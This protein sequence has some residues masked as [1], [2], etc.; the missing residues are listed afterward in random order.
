MDRVKTGSLIDRAKSNGPESDPGV[1]RP[2][3][4][5]RIHRLEGAL[6]KNLRVLQECGMREHGSGGRRIRGRIER[7]RGG[8]SGREA[9]PA[10][11]GR[12]GR[13]RRTPAPS[14]SP[15]AWVASREGGGRA[16]EVCRFGAVAAGR[17]IGITG[18]S[19]SPP[20][21][22][23]KQPFLSW[24]LRESCVG[25]WDPTTPPVH[26]DPPRHHPRRQLQLRLRAGV[27]DRRRVKETKVRVSLEDLSVCHLRCTARVEIW[28]GKSY[29]S[30][31]NK[32]MFMFEYHKLIVS[33]LI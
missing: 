21:P 23:G 6:A 10:R 32:D 12:W 29:S 25:D 30:V 33:Y 9:L 8:W 17:L 4:N 13:P 28:E 3:G 31:Q 24:V 16:G 15:A 26:L 2:R 14:P 18:G 27:L 19:R 11:S 7:R 20:F 1:K 22:A 5:G